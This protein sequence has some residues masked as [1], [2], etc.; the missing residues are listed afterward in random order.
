MENEPKREVQKYTIEDVVKAIAAKTAIYQELIAQNESDIEN[1]NKFLGLLKE[2]K[3]EEAYQVT[4]DMH[5][6]FEAI[7]N[8]LKDCNPSEI[9]SNITQDLLESDGGFRDIEFSKVI[10]REKEKEMEAKMEEMIA[11]GGPM[12]R[13]AEMVK[14]LKAE[15]EKID[16]SEEE[17]AEIPENVAPEVEKEEENTRKAW[18][19]PVN[20]EEGD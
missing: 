6:S 15:A 16:Y 9:M 19:K 10:Q 11:K 12:A 4:K 20:P 17:T 1:F 5:D 14:N 8:K 13:I 2:E 18:V 7:A 3:Y